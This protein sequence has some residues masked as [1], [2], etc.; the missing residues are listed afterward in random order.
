MKKVY[1]WHKRRDGV[2]VVWDTVRVLASAEGY[3]M[4]RRKGAMPFV[5][6]DI[7]LTDEGKHLPRGKR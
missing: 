2:M 7:D 6:S 4:V 5:V 3:S 1:K